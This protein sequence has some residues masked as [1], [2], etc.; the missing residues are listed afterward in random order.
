[1]IIFT[2]KFLRIIFL[3]YLCTPLAIVKTKKR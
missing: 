1:M 2:K 3:F